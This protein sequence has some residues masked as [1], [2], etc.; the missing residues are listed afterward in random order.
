MFFFYFVAIGQG[1]CCLVRCPDGRVV[2]VDCGQ[3]ANPFGDPAWPLEGQLVLREWV[4]DR[5]NTADAL[6][7]THSDADHHN[8][9]VRFFSAGHLVSDFT[10]AYTDYVIPEGYRLSHTN[11]GAIYISSGTD[12]NGLGNYRAGALNQN[13][14]SGYLDTDGVC[15]VTIA[16]A[17]NDLNSLRLWSPHDGF[18]VPAP[19]DGLGDHRASILSGNVDGTP[20]SVDIIAGN[21]PLGYGGVAD[22]STAANA[23]S[24]ITLFTIGEGK[25]LLCGDATFST[26]RFLLDVH[27]DAIREVDLVL[28]PHHG[29]EEASGPEFVDCVK[30]RAAV[31]SCGYLEHRHLHPRYAALGGWRAAVEERGGLVPPHDLDY[32][33]GATN[34]EVTAQWEEWNAEGR[35]MFSNE[36]R[37]FWALSHARYERFALYQGLSDGKFLY[38]EEIL[39]NLYA[40]SQGSCSYLLGPQGL[41][42]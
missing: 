22:A 17:N 20:W 40:T 26:E 4:R 2:V 18:K 6:V 32:W 34:D 14:Y 42:S 13:V 19:W 39:S 9:V 31:V 12:E 3:T 35:E 7:L 33:I 1:N 30:P 24:L 41:V 37:F 27:A 21:V 28:V 10:P 5:G 11:I 38:K 36:S 25:A 8:Q 29:S 16:H 15:E 23:A